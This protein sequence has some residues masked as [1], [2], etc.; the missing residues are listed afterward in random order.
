MNREPETDDTRLLNRVLSRY[1]ERYAALMRARPGALNEAVE[2]L[3]AHP[4][5]IR[6]VLLRSSYTDPL[7]IG[8]D[9]DRSL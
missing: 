9:L 5:E 8:G 1:P 6:R 2:I 4:N 3:I 7:A